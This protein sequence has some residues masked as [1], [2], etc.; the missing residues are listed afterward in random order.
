MAN[1]CNGIEQCTVKGP[2]ISMLQHGDSMDTNDN[3]NAHMPDSASDQWAAEWRMIFEAG[4]RYG[5]RCRLRGLAAPKVLL[6]SHS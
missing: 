4:F 1:P 3:G 5:R 2:V 6:D